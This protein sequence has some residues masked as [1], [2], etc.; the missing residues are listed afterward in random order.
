MKIGY[1]FL[2]V[3]IVVACR[4]KYVAKVNMP[5]NGYL[6]V[7]GFINT[8]NAATNFT[9]SRSSSLDSTKIIPETGAEMEVQSSNGASYPLNENSPGK[10]SIGQIPVDT[11]LQYRIHI[12]TSSSKEYLSDLEEA[13]ISPPI[14]SVAWIA[15]TNAIDI[16]IS[17]HDDQKKSIYYQWEYVE[18]WQYST[19]LESG[20]IWTMPETL[21][22]RDASESF[23][24]YCWASDSSTQ[25]IISSSAKLTK[26][27]IY[28]FPIA[29][30]SYT[31]NKL[32]NL[33]SIL[34]KQYALTEDWYEWQQRLQSNTEQLGSIFDPQPSELTGNIHC[35]TNPAE[36]TIGFVGCTSISQKRIFISHSEILP[37]QL[38]P[39]GYEGCFQ[40]EYPWYSKTTD[41]I[42]SGSNTVITG[43]V[44]YGGGITNVFISSV[45]CVDCRLRGG[46][47]IKPSFWP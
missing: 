46:T 8:G 28:E 42:L 35:I 39:T 7:E 30:V 26:D 44:F 5:T 16:S 2:P 25:I 20:Y 12:K 15:D 29:Q 27:V 17:T 43:L 34:V 45:G 23:P 32:T 18:T 13:K 47:G 36:L 6:V 21:V 11:S 1:W 22:P 24:A 38:I 10:Y 40:S 9:L 19:M 3:M 33:Y 14:D 31:T 4:E 37:N 41:S